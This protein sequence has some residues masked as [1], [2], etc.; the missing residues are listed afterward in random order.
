[1]VEEYL[2]N[3]GLSDAAWYL[4][5]DVDELDK[6]L[7]ANEVRRV[8]FPSLDEFA[9]ALWEEPLS[10]E[11]WRAPDV[12]VEFAQSSGST[13]AARAAALIASWER[14][15]ARH[16]RAQALAGA[17]LSAAAVAAAFIVLVLAR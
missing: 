7:C 8:V 11:S 12:C 17:L 1:M 4:P 13:E 16:R 9:T 14:H 3:Q 5:R 15:Q 10:L 2:R 6:A